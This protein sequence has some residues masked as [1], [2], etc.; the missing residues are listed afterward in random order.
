MNE[1]P[2]ASR[3]LTQVLVNWRNGDKDAL[4]EMSG[5]PYD[6]LRRLARDV[7]EI[8]C[9][10]F[11]WVFAGWRNRDKAVLGRRRRALREKWRQPG[12]YMFAAGRSDPTIPA[13]DPPL[14]QPCLHWQWRCGST[15]AGFP[16]LARFPSRRIAFWGLRQSSENAI[17]TWVCQLR[18]GGGSW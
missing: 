7:R 12:Q 10:P 13:A 1:E 3:D 15:L 2:P 11:F 17:G 14:Q 9:G 18:Y 16:A 8:L 6:E 4:E 5:V